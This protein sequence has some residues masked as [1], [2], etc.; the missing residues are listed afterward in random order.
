MVAVVVVVV[1][2]VELGGIGV[3][4]VV[5]A[6]ALCALSLR[7]G[8]HA[9]AWRPLYVAFRESQLRKPKKRGAMAGNWGCLVFAA[10]CAVSLRTSECRSQA[11]PS[12]MLAAG[13]SAS[14]EQCVVS[15]GSSVSLSSCEAAV[16][17]GDG[18]DLCSFSNGQL[19]SVATSKCLALLGGDV[20]NGGKAGLVDC[21]AALKTAGSQ[22]EECGARPV[23]ACC[24]LSRCVFGRCWAADSSRSGLLAIIVSLRAALLR[25]A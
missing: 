19:V 21:D 3:V 12:F 25:G 5:A 11:N 7:M 16:S 14:A 2:V 22:W 10:F 24:P 8:L 1:V 20:T 23:P 15:S 9:V 17:A 18:A 6:V 13:I 4:V